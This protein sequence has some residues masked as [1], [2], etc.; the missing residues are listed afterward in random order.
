MT[1]PF[2]K[3]ELTKTIEHF[4][5]SKGWIYRAW[6]IFPPGCA[7]LVKV[8]IEHEGHP[9]IPINKSDYIK[10]DDYVFELPMF[11]EVPEEPYQLTFEGWNEDE[12]YNHEITLMLLVL[13][14]AFILPVGATEGIMESLK[15]LI[16]R[17]ELQY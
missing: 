3:T 12:S 15:S 9:I 11:Y 13:P 14:K 6:V 1:F 10:A 17:E 2:G 4:G 7:G 8:R 16:I 5:I